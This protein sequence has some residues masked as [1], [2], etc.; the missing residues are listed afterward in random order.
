MKPVIRLVYAVGKQSGSHM[1]AYANKG[2]LPWKFCQ[3]DMDLFKA[4][5]ENSVIL[6]GSG[7]WQ[8]VRTMFPGRPTAVMSSRSEWVKNKKGD[9][10][11]HQYDCSMAEAIKDLLNKYP[12]K[13]IC[14]IGGPKFLN[15]AANFATETHCTELHLSA[16]AKVEYD[17]GI[18]DN[19]RCLLNTGL[20]YRE[21]HAYY[22]HPHEHEQITMVIQN[23]W[24]AEGINYA[25][26]LKHLGL[27]A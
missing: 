3:K 13:I 16:D 12:E 2:D 18:H 26:K 6:M 25:A 7:T 4:S 10:A 19:D 8:S 15:Q 21:T 27:N 24:Y 14:I 11:N 22:L 1:G 20:T 23:V 9:F 5:T 17:V